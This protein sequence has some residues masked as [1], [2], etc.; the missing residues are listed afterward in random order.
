M[1]RLVAASGTSE[2]MAR[3][4]ARGSSEDAHPSYLAPERIICKEDT[5]QT[6]ENMSNA[7]GGGLRLL[8][9]G[10]LLS[11]ARCC[12]ADSYAPRRWRRSQP[13]AVDNYAKHH[14]SDQIRKGIRWLGA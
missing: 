13:I 7:Q 6:I 11:L 4:R 8:S 2:I 10:M 1:E 5:V 9:F 14:A 3:G 12:T